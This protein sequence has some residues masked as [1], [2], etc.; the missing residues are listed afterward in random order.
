MG[1]PGDPAFISA[2]QT[3]DGEFTLAL[4]GLRLIDVLM[5]IAL[6]D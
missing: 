1:E 3:G 6:F 5:P 2:P 4:T